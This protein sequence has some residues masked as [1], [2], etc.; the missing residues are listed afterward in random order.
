MTGRARALTTIWRHATRLGAECTIF[1][2]GGIASTGRVWGLDVSYRYIWTRKPPNIGLVRQRLVTGD[3]DFSL[4]V[5][6]E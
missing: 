1:E 2:N 3:L 5:D 6:G 4:Y